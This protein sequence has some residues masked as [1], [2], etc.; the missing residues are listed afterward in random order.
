[1][2]PSPPSSSLSVLDGLHQIPETAEPRLEVKIGEGFA[3]KN[4]PE[5]ERLRVTGIQ[6]RI[7]GGGALDPELLQHR[8]QAVAPV[9]ARIAEMG[10]ILRRTARDV[11][12]EPPV[13]RDLARDALRVEPVLAVAVGVKL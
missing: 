13:F 3:V 11:R 2:I 5:G 1:P 9:A 8:E 10:E 7:S 4:P 12:K 6:P